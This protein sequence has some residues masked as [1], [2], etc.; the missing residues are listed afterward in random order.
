MAGCNSYLKHLRVYG[1][2]YLMLSS[3]ATAF[4]A[5]KLSGLRRNQ[6]KCRMMEGVPGPILQAFISIETYR[7]LLQL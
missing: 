2:L 5:G 7:C 1:W 6:T 4:P 3:S